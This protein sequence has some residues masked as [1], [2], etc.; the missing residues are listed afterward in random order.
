MYPYLAMSR[1]RAGRRPREMVADH[2]G[3]RHQGGV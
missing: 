1:R 2:Q 3:C